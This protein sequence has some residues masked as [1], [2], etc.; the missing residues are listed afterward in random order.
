M[1]VDKLPTLR[2]AVVT[3]AAAGAIVP[4][5]I[6]H[7]TELLPQGTYEPI[8]DDRTDAPPAVG[9]PAYTY[10][11]V[12]NIVANVEGLVD[13][14]VDVRQVS[15]P[16]LLCAAEVTTGEPGDTPSTPCT[17]IVR[18]SNRRATRAVDPTPP[19]GPSDECDTECNRYPVVHSDAN[20]AR[21][22]MDVLGEVYRDR[23][24]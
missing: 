1:Y 21:R 14:R 17:T 18:P 13:V 15:V 3:A 10:R 11:T 6:I 22:G 5:A 24:N 19:P 8:A 2:P 12:P 7:R 20:P 16:V 4:C 23:I 9:P